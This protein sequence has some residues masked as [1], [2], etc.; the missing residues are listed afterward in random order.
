MPSRKTIRMHFRRI[1][2][3]HRKLCI[4]HWHTWHK[5]PNATRSHWIHFPS[6]PSQPIP[7]LLWGLRLQRFL[8][9]LILSSS[10]KWF[11]RFA[12]QLFWHIWV[13][14]ASWY[15]KRYPKMM[16]N[17]P[18]LLSRS[19]VW[20]V[21]LI[22][23][24]LSIKMFQTLWWILLSRSLSLGSLPNPWSKSGNGTYTDYH[25]LTQI[26]KTSIPVY[27]AMSLASPLGSLLGIPYTISVASASAKVHRSN[28]QSV[29]LLFL[30]DH[31]HKRWRQW[32][33]LRM[34]EP[35]PAWTQ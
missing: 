34:M 13:W 17:D 21:S 7:S 11:C 19:W 1:V 30:V 12:D 27:P 32:W 28:F 29:P 25:W 26:W 9:P 8:F 16:Q 23:L 4:Q 15:P 14:V 24:Q 18:N 2:E 22:P 10:A 20:P 31:Q 5:V 6:F 33:Q 35:R 3:K